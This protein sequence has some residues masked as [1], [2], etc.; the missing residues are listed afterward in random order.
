MTLRDT[1][2]SKQDT[3]INA[4][5][6]SQTNHTDNKTQK[7]H[8]VSDVSNSPFHENR[9]SNHGGPS[10]APKPRLKL[11]PANS[12][13]WKTL[14]ED[15]ETRLGAEFSARDISAKST[16]ELAEAF[17]RIV[18]ETMARHFE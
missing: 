11:P 18:Y 2:D 7:E 17:G 14:D 15:L 9:A 8:K 6:H 3:D 10:V 5:T 4:D 13:L 16:S 1:L 12:T